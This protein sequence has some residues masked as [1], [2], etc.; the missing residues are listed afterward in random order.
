MTFHE[1]TLMRRLCV[2]DKAQR[3]YNQQGQLVPR[4]NPLNGIRK[5]YVYGASPLKLRLPVLRWYYNNNR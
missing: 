2:G 1:D 4:A 5:P 3:R